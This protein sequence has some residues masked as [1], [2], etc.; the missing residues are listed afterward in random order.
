M[1]PSSPHHASLVP[2]GAAVVVLALAA[3]LAGRPRDG[4]VPYG[5]GWS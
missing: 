1:N 3:V 2:T 4:L 5:Y